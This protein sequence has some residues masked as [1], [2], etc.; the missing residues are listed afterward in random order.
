MQD[1]L[2]FAIRLSGVEGKE[3]GGG[4]G[5]GMER[6]VW[7]SGETRDGTPVYTHMQMCNVCTRMGG[8]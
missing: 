7:A 5:G 1:I 3:R 6:L 4:G 2:Y 8:M